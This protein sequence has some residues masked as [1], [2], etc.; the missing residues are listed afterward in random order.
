MTSKMMR[1]IHQ[2]KRLLEKIR[3]K[4]I[5]RKGRVLLRNH[6]TQAARKM[7]MKR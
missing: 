2:A 3:R 5:K 1:R 4:E 6:P 7:N